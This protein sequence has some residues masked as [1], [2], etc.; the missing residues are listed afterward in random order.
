MKNKALLALQ[1]IDFCIQELTLF[2][3]MHP[4][5]ELALQLLSKYLNQRDTL[6]EAVEKQNGP[7]TNL[8]H[9]NNEWLW[10]KNPWPWDKED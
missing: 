6:K 4:D 9:S 3:D 5:N 2:L 8:D 7:L 1:E 10:A